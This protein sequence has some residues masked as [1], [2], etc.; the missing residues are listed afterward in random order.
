MS[1]NNGKVSFQDAGKRSSGT[2]GEPRDQDP[3]KHLGLYKTYDEVP[4]EHRLESFALA[5]E[6]RDVW[7]EYLDYRTDLSDDTKNRTY[8]WCFNAWR[9]FIE[10]EEGTHH[11]LATPEQFERFIARELEENKKWTVYSQRFSRLY[12]FYE[13]L[14]HNVDYEHRYNVALMAAALGGAAYEMWLWRWSENREEK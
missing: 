4:D 13:W 12:G 8:K 11:A 7:Q 1:E 9:P 3:K 6:G 5:Y 10:E 2:T 14:A